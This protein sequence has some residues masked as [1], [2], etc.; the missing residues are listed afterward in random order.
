MTTHTTQVTQAADFL[1]IPK[2][3]GRLDYRG[4]DLSRSSILRLAE[5]N[6]IKLVK[7]RVTGS[8]K[9]RTFILRESLDAWLNRQL[10]T[11]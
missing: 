7:L 5:A 2:P 8:A 4:I 3:S 1:A 6:Q 10:T 9:G 11:A